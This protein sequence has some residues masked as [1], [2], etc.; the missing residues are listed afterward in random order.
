M[1]DSRARIIRCP[2]VPAGFCINIFGTIWTR[3]PH[4]IT[5]RILNHER[6]HTAQMR[7]LLFIPFYIVY[8]IE[9]L[10]RLVEYRHWYKA[11]MAISFERE[12]YS[13]DSDAAYLAHRPH[14][15]QWRK[16]QG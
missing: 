14:Y 11:Y 16:K 13:H 6:I 8:F 5:P 3:S 10:L 12:A 7:E 15:A 4:Q 2:L 1:H 9:W